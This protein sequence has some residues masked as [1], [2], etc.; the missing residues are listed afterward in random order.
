[1]AYAETLKMYVDGKDLADTFGGVFAYDYE[2]GT[3][4]PKTYTVDIPCGGTIDLTESLTGDVAYEQLEQTFNLLFGLDDWERTRTKLMNYLHGRSHEYRL[5]I[6]PGYTRTGRFTIES[7][8][9]VGRGQNGIA[10]V[11]IKVAADPYKLKERCMY[12]LNAT[13]GRWYR[14]ESGRRPVHPVIECEN[15]CYV[16][17]DGAE[18]LVPPG[19]Y[20]LND[21][22]FTEG[23][24]R[25]YV[26]SRKLF[27][28]TW[29]DFAAKCATWDDANGKTWDELQVMNSGKADAPRSWGDL[30][31]TTWSDLSQ[32]HWYELNFEQQNPEATSVYI[33][34]DWEDL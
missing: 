4:E 31:A 10:K 24:N 15:A 29:A 20:R 26:N 5:S 1:M 22:L 21:V 14:F 9:H 11:E 19:S 25:L 8:D 13:G 32:T 17:V 34:Y 2:L 30:S 28:T 3:P 7:V 33:S 12:R 23:F 6:D 16:L 27:F 18:Q